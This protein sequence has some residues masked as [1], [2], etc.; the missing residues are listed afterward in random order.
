MAYTVLSLDGG[1]IRGVISVVLLERLCREPSIEGW[2]DRVRLIAG[3]STGGLIALGIAAGIPLSD[4]RRLYEQDGPRIFDDSLPDDIVDLG[5]LIGAD[6]PT[7]PRKQV[8]SRILGAQTLGDLQRRVL[9]TAFDLDNGAA[10]PHE[11]RWKPKLFHNFPGE[12]SD[13]ALSAF[14]V[15]LYTSAAPT[16]FPTVD[17]YVDG[18]V[19]APNPSMCALAQTQDQRTGENVPLA[20]VRLLSIGTGEPLQ[21]VEGNALDWGYT[22]WARPI[23]ELMLGGTSGIADFQCAQILRE[24]YHRLAPVLPANV[25]FA[26]DDADKIPA[27]I[28]F[29]SGVDLAPAIAWI[30]AN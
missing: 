23:I 30:R 7:E 11:R 25:D 26:L 1:G 4:L 6:Y 8:F 29:A 28:A 24:R 17:G 15:A 19:F 2:L 22:Q 16:Y 21:R 3:T 27:M 5:K 9:I 20:D 13:A 10:E 18:G 14:K 12:D